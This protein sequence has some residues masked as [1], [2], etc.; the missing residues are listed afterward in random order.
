MTRNKLEMIFK[1]K[2]KVFAFFFTEYIHNVSKKREKHEI[3]MT[4][5]K[6]KKKGL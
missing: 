3:K 6:G 4:Q 1:V 2:I 5:K